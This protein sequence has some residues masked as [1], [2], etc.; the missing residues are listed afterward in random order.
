MTPVIYLAESSPLFTFFNYRRS[1]L[2]WTPLTLIQQFLHHLGVSQLSA[3]GE[4][5]TRTTYLSIKETKMLKSSIPYFLY[6]IIFITIKFYS[7]KQII[8]R[9]LN[10]KNY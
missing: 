6:I 7:K 10:E 5:T 3:P 4:K 1:Y 9:F 8:L 2:H